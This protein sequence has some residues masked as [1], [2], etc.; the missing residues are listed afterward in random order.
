[1]IEWTENNFIVVSDQFRFPYSKGLMARSLMRA[2]I[3][4]EA[5]YEIASRI[6]EDILREGIK[7][8][9][10]HELKKIALRLVEEKLGS[11]AASDYEKWKLDTYRIYVGAA[12]KKEPFSRG[13]LAQSLLAAGLD[14]DMA[15]CV[16]EK[17]AAELSE[18]GMGTITRDDLRSFTYRT[19]LSDFGRERARHY[20]LWRS[21][22]RPDRPLILLFGGATGTG[23]SSLAVEIAH[24]L[25]ITR[26]IGT[27]T[28]REIMRGMFS[29]E[30][31]P[32]I[33]ESSFAVWKTWKRP[34]GKNEDT[35]LNAFQ[36]QS[37]RVDVGVSAIKRRAIK[38]NLSMVI[39]GVHLIPEPPDQEIAGKAIEIPVLICTTDESLHRNRFVDRGSQASDRP[40]QKY[41]ENF[42]SIR[43]IQEALIA[44][45]LQNDIFIVD[46]LDFDETVSKIIQFLTR[47]MGEILK[48]DLSVYE[49]FEE[50]KKE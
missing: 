49:T 45:A 1:M 15:H 39:E 28:I 12:Q 27:D 11:R 46:N 9:R 7:E 20:L 18:R 21:L 4:T 25:G 5:A 50:A 17:M 10:R 6:Q 36:E 41:L 26:V 23:K 35:V 19:I 30:L 44:K 13:I 14:P 34:L 22:K 43:N 3:A 31:L 38:E 29:R 16:A 33:Y 47:R 48:P 40:S 24:R 2:G 42:S 32:S 37:Q 8:I